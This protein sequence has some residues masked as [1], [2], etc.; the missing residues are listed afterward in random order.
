M[1]TC[2]LAVFVWLVITVSP[3]WGLVERR[4]EKRF[5]VPARGAALRV[6]TSV[7]LVR[8][9]ESADEGVI[10]VVMHQSSDVETEA[11][12][13]ARLAKL[14]FKIAA[15]DG[16][17]FARAK[18]SA[19][20]LWAWEPW[21]PVNLVYEIKVPR[22]CDV[23]VSTREGGI[24]VGRVQGQVTLR[25]D[26]GKIFVS[27]IDGRVDARSESGSVALTAA[28]GDVS[29]QTQT[30]NILVGR[31]GGR[32][33]LESLG[34]FIELQRASGPVWV[35]GSGSNAKIG[36]VAP[37][38]HAADIS[39][40]GGELALV[41]ENDIACTLRARSSIL[42]KVAIRGQLPLNVLSGGAGRARLDA[43]IN[44]GGP[45]IAAR[46][47]GGDVIVSGVQ[48][49]AAIAATPSDQVAFVR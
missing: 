8:I 49:L 31:V 45:R 42:G 20:L 12:M 40:S 25:T 36:F 22:R 6:D 47:S 39:L 48:P 32:A 27:E 7:G 46:V 38:R 24:V 28:S 34:G 26:S 43:E 9:E 44:G 3:V 14:D 37:V 17:V 41:L 18:P 29:V 33:R 19:A 30:G 35:R 16:V 2:R 5:E 1:R 21:P 10:E 11:E 4:V 23:E 15:E 13:D